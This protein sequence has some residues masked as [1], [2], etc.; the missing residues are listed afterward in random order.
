MSCWRVVVL[1]EDLDLEIVG[2]DGSPLQRLISDP[3]EDHQ[4]IPR[5]GRSYDL[6]THQSS[7]S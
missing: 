6:L 7:M 5:S 2:L 1:I 3:T 4:N